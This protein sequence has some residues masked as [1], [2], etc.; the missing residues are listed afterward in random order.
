MSS[1]VVA[2]SE[3]MHE[4]VASHLEA[5]DAA[6]QPTVPASQTLP[7][8]TLLPLV[9]GVLL[10]ILFGA[11]SLYL[12]LKVGLTVSAS[13]PVAV[14]S[15]TFFRLI[16][17]LGFRNTNIL[18][19]NIVQTVGSSGEALAF[20]LGVTMPALLLLGFD[21]TFVRLLLVALI[22]GLL[23]G[24][25][26]IPLRR[27]L[28]VHQH[29]KLKYPEGVACAEILKAG[30]SDEP[31]DR[32]SSSG[33]SK[34]ESVGSKVVFV[35]FG[36]GFAYHVAMSVLKLWKEVPE[37]VFGP[38]LR[39]AS[40]E[41]EI[42][43]ALIGVGY[44]IGPRIAAILCAG[45]IMSYLV[46]IPLISY[47]GE[48]WMT[49]LLP[50]DRPIGQ[51][52][53]Y[54]IRNAYILY[55]GAG[56]V[57]T[58]GI[59]SLFRSLPV[60]TYGAQAVL[61]DL[62]RSGMEGAALPRTA[63]DL[64]MR[65]VILSI[66]ALVVTTLLASTLNMNVVGALIILTLGFLFV[67]VSARLTGEIGS[68]SNPISGMALATL[69]L[70]C[71][72]L[73]VGGWTSPSYYVTALVVGAVVCI[74]AS[75][76]GTG[77]QVLKTG[78][79]VGATPSRQQVAILIGILSA[80]VVLG[81]ILLRLD[82]ASTVYVPRTTYEHLTSNVGRLAPDVV[83]RLDP[84]VPANVPGTPHGAY[85]Q[86]IYDPTAGRIIVAGLESGR[87]Y[88]VNEEGEVAFVVRENF[89]PKL[90]EPVDVSQLKRETLQ[91]L[92]RE[93]NAATYYVYWHESGGRIS[94]Y[95]VDE[96]G[97]LVYLVDPGIN[98]ERTF[99]TDGK[100]VEKF[101]AP[102]SVLMA[103]VIRGI[104]EGSLPWGLVLIGVMLAVVLELAGIP[105]LA[106]AVGVYLP[107]SSST[108]IFAG[109]L[110]R[111]LVD[112]KLADK[113]RRLQLSDEEVIAEGDRSPGVL[114]ASGYIAGAAIAGI[115]TAF[116]AGATYLR[117]VRRSLEEWATAYNPFYN[118]PNADLLALI[119]FLLLSLLLY[120]VGRELWLVGR[121]MAPGRAKRSRSNLNP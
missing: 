41:V 113:Y 52:S 75:S 65:F 3:K 2:Q 73:K 101:H 28:I 92:E 106:F 100:A 53:T 58:G 72:A 8:L 108:P 1:G 85:R 71:L 4:D 21:L 10:G 117:D 115:I 66:L 5:Q 96:K 26:I 12:V 19:N 7:E 16:S 112:R 22:G 118:G 83:K 61:S 56:A 110:V 79:L 47:F 14:I 43:P 13:I 91:G 40:I 38:P 31:G 90:P 111:W 45:G 33:V 18:E 78:Y 76:A 60:L 119:P 62:R 44:I 15:I 116:Y 39:S 84:F 102:K 57:V 36:I 55:I 20:G 50:G 37:K 105:S 69:L 67:A 68:S 86:L 6:Y 121:P 80:A 77:S 17:R 9:V 29:G 54:E 94:K 70:T 120:A 25:L 99:D 87:K 74:A 35:G 64:P 34:R 23:G 59:I 88:L 51:M 48:G 46:L 98:G 109:G 49:P 107:L 32:V 81:P 95:L 89:P 24:L 11:S 97:A 103:Y 27:T 82:S 93:S 63:R 104:L 114:M 42:S 30:A